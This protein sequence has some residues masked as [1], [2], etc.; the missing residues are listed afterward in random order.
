[1][2]AT[3]RRERE[4][5]RR[6]GVSA[7]VSDSAARVRASDGA[8]ACDDR[9]GD[10]GSRRWRTRRRRSSGDGGRGGE[11]AAEIKKPSVGKRGTRRTHI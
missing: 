7:R 1:M 5:E 6:R 2:G 4:G 3:A 9:S 8:R 11:G 10:L